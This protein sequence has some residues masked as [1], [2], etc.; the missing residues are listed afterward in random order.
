MQT[1]SPSPAHADAC[2]PMQRAIHGAAIAESFGADFKKGT[3]TFKVAPTDRVSSGQYILIPAIVARLAIEQEEAE[4]HTSTKLLPACNVVA[5][6]RQTSDGGTVL[7][8]EGDNGHEA[9]YYRDHLPSE[10]TRSYWHPAHWRGH[11]QRRDAAGRVWRS[12]ETY[13]QDD[14]G[15]LVAVQS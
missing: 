1:L 2:T 10:R 5:R 8:M 14:F 9:D 12:L 15:D 13:V 3:W 4:T 7:T 11:E 6:F